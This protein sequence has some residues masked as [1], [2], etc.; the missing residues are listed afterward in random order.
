MRIRGLIALFAL[1]AALAG[2]T[3]VNDPSAAQAEEGAQ[4]ER[5]GEVIV[6]FKPGTDLPSLAAALDGA[7]TEATAS[8]AGS[9][10]VLAS[11]DEGQSVDEA[12]ASLRA[13]P[14]VEFAEAE[15]VVSAAATPNDA[16]Y[17]AYQWNLP[18][19]ELPAAWDITT[20]GSPG[21]IVAVVDTG[22]DSTHPELSGKLV[23]GR[24]II[25]GNSNTAD[26]NFHGTF[27][28]GIIAANTNNGAGVAG[29]CWTCRIMP[30][31]VL[32]S[33]GQ[34]TN[35]NVAQGIDWAVANGAKVVNLSLGSSSSDSA[36]QTA[37]NNA[38]T[39]GV[40]VVAASGN[41]NSAVLYPAAYANSVAVGA[42]VEGSA[43]WSSSNYGAQLDVVAPGADVISTMCN[44]A[45][46]AGG[47]G[48]GSGTSF[49]APHVAGVVALLIASGVTDKTQIVSQLTST[50]TDIAPA[51]FDNFTGWGEVNAGAALDPGTPPAVDI[52]APADGVTVASSVN[53]V[54]DASD[55]DGIQRVWFYVD[56]VY[57]RSD[58][59]APYSALWDASGASAGSHV[60]RVRAYDNAGDYTDDVVS[61][62]VGGASDPVVNI[63]SPGDGSTVSGSVNIAADATDVDD[64][65]QRVWFYVDDVYLRSDALAPYSAIWDASAAALGPHTIRVRAYD[66]IG[67]YT[68]DTVTVDVGDATPPTVTI[69]SPG[70]GANGSGTV[71]ITADASDD[72]AVQRVWFYVDGL[73][74]RSDAL[75]PYSA[76]WDATAAG[77]G[78]HEVRVRAYDTNNNY[79][80]VTITVN[81]GDATP[82]TVTITSPA[83]GATVSGVVSIVA[84]VSDDTA[85]ERV[86]F[87]IDGVYLRSDAMAPYS[88]PWNATAAGEGPH[89]IRV[90]GYDTNG[91]YTDA[92]IN[93]TVT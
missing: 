37:V 31:K 93:V 23:A 68:D 48:I 39:A 40:V 83:G 55:D 71:N 12:L 67:N 9:R 10:L 89:E 19:I 62:N 78:S 91:N 1:V 33:S 65:V 5:T 24:N 66:N 52:T 45:G 54:A 57:L 50:A 35:F 79:T 6:R 25:A 64:G 20:G 18:Q 73:Y 84:D 8:T 51:G 56:N 75:A 58:A 69:T 59:S 27:V 74:L 90:R 85:V 15:Q 3:G 92:V 80:D 30:V 49:A 81:V 61:V 82:P 29:V 76:P 72:T 86:W 87:Y 41:S 53:I 17:A 36:M 28:A 13:D 7:E 34:G 63:A 46:Y 38:W 43:R 60:I 70:D 88:A 32:D 22:V 11:P 21:P 14:N 47:Y 4:P 16:H 77:E 26:D 42:T 2:M 44:C